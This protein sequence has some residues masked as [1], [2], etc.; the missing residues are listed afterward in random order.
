MIVGFTGTRSE[1]TE[2]QINNLVDFLA[3]TEIKEVHHGDCQGADKLFHGAVRM[4]K[5]STTKIVVH[6]P[7]IDL[8]RAFCKGDEI[9]NP[10]TYRE[11]NAMIVEECEI[12][13]VFP[14]ANKEE[15]RSGTWMAARMAKKKNKPYLIFYPDGR[16]EKEF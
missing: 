8:M 4:V 7:D 16:R 5:G 3:T 13:L 15:L 1:L 14:K 2:E 11:R 10:L 12:L 6:P 9:R